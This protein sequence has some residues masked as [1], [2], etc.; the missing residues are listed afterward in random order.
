MEIVLNASFFEVHSAKVVDK[1][2]NS[3]IKGRACMLMRK[4]SKKQGMNQNENRK[5]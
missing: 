2:C 5:P 1:K 3:V 4:A